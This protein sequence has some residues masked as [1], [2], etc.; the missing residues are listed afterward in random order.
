M[1]RLIL[2]LI[3]FVSFVSASF[4]ENIF[5][6]RFFEVKLD[7]PVSLSNNLV[8]LQSI[9]QKKVVIDLAEIADKMPDD[10]ASIKANVGPSLSINL[11]IPRGLILGVNIG[12]QAEVSAGLS[13]DIFEFLGKGNGG[14]GNSFTEKT[15]NTYADLFANVSVTGGWNA[16]KSRLAVTGTVFS[17]IAHMDAGDSYIKIYN[18]AED[19]TF[20]VQASLDAKMYAVADMKND[21]SDIMGI[22]NLASKNM[23]FDLAADYQLD[24]ARFLTLG[25]KANIPLVPSK[26]DRLA[27][28]KSDF[29]Y[30]TS[31]DDLMKNEESSGEGGE[32]GNEGSSSEESKQEAYTLSEFEQLSNPYIIHRPLKLGLSA[33]FHPFGTLLSTNGYFGIG[34]RHPF[35]KNSDETDFYFDYSV[36][37]KLSLWNIINFELTH[38]YYDQVFKNEFALALNIR[39]VEVDAGISF[40]SA[41]L[42]KSFQGAGAG[43]YVTVCIGF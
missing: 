7:M 29:T 2:S 20:G 27:S 4:A 25:A 18:N 38:S 14:M 6:H 31:L 39:L 9:F 43:A 35:A 8:D 1:K 22:V 11:D 26:L 30:E 37:G 24:F 17:A 13:K 40:Q 12:A 42:A 10:G 5:A 19:N 23:G 41:S 32:S 33:N 21:M 15:S 3:L 34:V 28:V 36:G 16:K